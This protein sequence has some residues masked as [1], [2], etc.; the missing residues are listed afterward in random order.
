MSADI[1]LLIL[2]QGRL[3]F[4]KK[5][6]PLGAG[7]SAVPQAH[8]PGGYGAAVH[9]I[10]ATHCEHVPVATVRSAGLLHELVWEIDLTVFKL[11]R[12]HLRACPSDVKFL[13]LLGHRQ[14]L[15]LKEYFRGAVG[16]EKV[17]VGAANCF[18]VSGGGDFHDTGA[19]RGATAEDNG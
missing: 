8:A 10:V 9:E 7:L 5:F 15:G 6:T 4:R 17:L 13:P 3:L 14:P 12:V 11:H 18:G 1:V 16:Q 2:P 19:G